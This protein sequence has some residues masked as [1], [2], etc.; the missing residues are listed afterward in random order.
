MKANASLTLGITPIVWMEMIE[1]A[2]NKLD[3]KLVARFLGRFP[4]VYPTQADI[5]WAMRQLSMYHLS[6]NVDSFDCLIAAPSYH[7]QLPVCTRNLK[8]FTSLLGALAQQ[9]Y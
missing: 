7:L 3:Q 2:E 8:H 5:D 6:H 9:P 4:L 1:G